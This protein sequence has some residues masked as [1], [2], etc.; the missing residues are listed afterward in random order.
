[1]I[2]ILKKQVDHIL[3]RIRET[4]YLYGRDMDEIQLI[5]VSKTIPPEMI[6]EAIECGLKTFGESYIQESRE[7]IASIADSSISWHFIGHLQ[8][9]KAKYAV[10]LF[11]LIHTVDSIKLAY[12][13]D[14]QAQK[15][16]KVQDILLQVNVGMEGS[17]SG[18]PPE[19][20]LD[21][22]KAISSLQHLKVKGLMA[23]P[24][25]YNS[26]ERVAPYFQTLR[27]LRDMI[28]NEKIPNIDMK[29]LSMGMTGDFEVAIREGATL[30][31]IG[32]AIFGERG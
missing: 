10:K 20:V 7:K 28:R 15:I 25:V 14:R 9:N 8:S 5:A 21:L 29:E 6:R 17:K 27:K 19:Y 16:N 26:P 24:P 13:L 3:N 30:I 22:T 32:T 18:A 23:I 11:D 12:E 31:R 4:A 2:P 1:M